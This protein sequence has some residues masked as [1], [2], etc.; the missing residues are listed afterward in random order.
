ME[1]WKGGIMVSK[2]GVTLVVEDRGGCTM[3]KETYRAV[4]KK[5]VSQGD[6]VLDISRFRKKKGDVSPL[7]PSRELLKDWNQ[8]RIVWK[9]YV[10]RYYQQLRENKAATSLIE[11]IA[12]LAAREDVWLVCMERGYPCHRFLVKEIVEKMLVARG[13]FEESEDYSEYYR[14]YKNLTR[15]EIM[16]LSDSS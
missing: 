1:H 2:D 7:A 9:D 10:E 4:K 5:V 13:V 16:A 15:S 11:E 6:V 8:D 12:H 14:L 3:I